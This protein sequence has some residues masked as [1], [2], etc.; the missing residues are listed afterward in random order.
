M[1]H[2]IQILVAALLVIVAALVGMSKWSSFPFRPSNLISRAR[3]SAL[4][5]SDKQHNKEQR[6]NNPPVELV[7]SYNDT[8]SGSKYDPHLNPQLILS[9]SKFQPFMM[10]GKNEGITHESLP[11]GSSLTP[12]RGIESIIEV[13]E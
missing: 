13:G 4:D 9:G 5:L 2:N 1:I 6:S 3:K 7:T 10:D 11:L 8:D 12:L